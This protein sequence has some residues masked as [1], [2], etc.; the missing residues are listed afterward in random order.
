VTLSDGPRNLTT[1]RSNSRC[2][3]IVVKRTS[4]LPAPKSEFDPD[5]TLF[6]RKCRP[7]F[8]GFVLTLVCGLI[9][10]R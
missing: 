8:A 10:N 5:R 9:R 7:T 4:Q 6:N 3:L 1:K 2:R